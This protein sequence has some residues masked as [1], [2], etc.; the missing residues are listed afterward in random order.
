[1]SG[2]AGCPEVVSSEGDEADME[3]SGLVELPAQSEPVVSS[4]FS[5]SI[6][7]FEGNPFS[8]PDEPTERSVG[9][10]FPEPAHAE[11]KIIR[12]AINNAAVC[13]TVWLSVRLSECRMNFRIVFILPIRLI[14]KN[15]ASAFRYCMA[16]IASAAQKPATP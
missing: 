14:H 11:A 8:E 12:I 15:R 2:I 4:G 3:S 6:V 1:M 7:M 10:I 5:E 13:F 9:A 16:A